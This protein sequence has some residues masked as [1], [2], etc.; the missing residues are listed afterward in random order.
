MGPL[1]S[2]QIAEHLAITQQRAR[3]RAPALEKDGE[4][5]RG[6]VGAGHDL[7]AGLR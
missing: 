1:T 4:L 3:R 6:G 5:K 7:G 2:A